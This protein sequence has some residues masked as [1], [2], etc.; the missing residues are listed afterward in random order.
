[1]VRRFAALAH[2]GGNL[3]RKFAVL[4][5]ESRV[6]AIGLTNLTFCHTHVGDVLPGK[7]HAPLGVERETRLEL[8][9]FC[10]EGRRSARLSYSRVA[11]GSH[12]FG[13]NSN[14]SWC[15]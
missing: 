13:Q 4:E 10:L 1:M 6:T 9:T 11:R 14:R 12:T 15:G 3:A 2:V 8:A 7:Q 5:T